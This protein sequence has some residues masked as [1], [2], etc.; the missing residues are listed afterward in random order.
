MTT[1]GNCEF[2]GEPVPITAVAAFPVKGWEVERD[3]GGANRILGR[4]REPNRIAH[5]VC[6]EHHV[7]HG[8]Q[9]SML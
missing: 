7:H 6:A 5:A 8:Q 1:R 4:E 9:T 2:C 3:G